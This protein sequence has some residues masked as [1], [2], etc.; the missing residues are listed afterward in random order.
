MDTPAFHR[1]HEFIIALLKEELADSE[2]DILEIASGSGQHAL[3][4]SKA[5]PGHVIWPSDFNPE[6]VKS[7]KAWRDAGRNA[8]G[9]EN[10]RPPFQLDVTLKDWG[11]DAPNRPSQNLRAIINLN[12]V[13]ISP[14]QTAQGLFRGAGHALAKTGKLFLYGPFKKNGAHTAPSNAEFDQ[15]LRAR[16]PAWG[17]RDMSELEGIAE[18]HGL[19][20]NRAQPMPANNFTLIF[21]RGK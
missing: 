9:N 8:E 2:G 5:L 4:F 14:I 15:T 20:L 12:M 18:Q 3:A 7:I 10:L 19:R 16:D 21:S 11:I 17:I 1:N 6:H 13:H